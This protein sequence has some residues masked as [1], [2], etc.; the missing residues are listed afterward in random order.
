MNFWDWLRHASDGLNETQSNIVITIFLFALM[1]TVRRLLVQSVSRLA[2]DVPTRYRWRKN[3]SYITYGIGI[4]S[5][6]FIWSN[7]FASFATFLGL[8]SAGLA[9]A[10]KDP[11]A[12]IAA[13]YY[14]LADKPFKVGDRIQLGEHMGDI[15]DIGIFQTTMI[16]IG[17]WVKADQSTGR[18]IHLPNSKVFTGAVLNFSA[19]LNH[20]W[21]EIRLPL[22]LDSNWAKAKTIM[23]EILDE[24]APKLSEEVYEQLEELSGKYFIFSTKL[25]PIV[26]TSIEDNGIVLTMRYMCPVRQRRASAQVL[27]EAILNRLG[28]MKDI[29]FSYNTLRILNEQRYFDED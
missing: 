11:I 7:R 28:P 1:W 2:S 25:A 16:E 17:N 5:I 8:V 6:V 13:W 10:F 22:T 9:I 18:L 3:V 15:I 12:N 23:Q 29:R 24:L 19:L 14:I 27:F 20:I 21:N 26:Y 4:I